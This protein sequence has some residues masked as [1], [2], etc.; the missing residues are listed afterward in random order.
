MCQLIQFM[1]IKNLLNK[2]PDTLLFTTNTRRKDLF[3]LY[4]DICNIYVQDWLKYKKLSL[5]LIR[6]SLNG[7]N[8]YS[9]MVSMYYILRFL[10]VFCGR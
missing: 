7:H 9:F 1:Y 8:L 3:F 10:L 6:Y 5:Q 4:L 2:I